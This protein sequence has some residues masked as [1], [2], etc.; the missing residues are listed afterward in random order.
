MRCQ[1]EA[2]AA[3]KV[4]LKLNGIEGL[5]LWLNGTAVPAERDLELNLPAGLHTLTLAVD[6]SQRQEGLRIELDDVPGSAAR[7]KVVG[8]K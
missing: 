2:T 3:G 1:L 7:A 5:T 4:R 6:W 8:G